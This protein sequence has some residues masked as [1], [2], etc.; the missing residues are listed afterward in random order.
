[1][2]AASSS[3]ATAAASSRPAV[4]IAVAKAA[5]AARDEAYA[6]AEKSR[7]GYVYGDGAE[8]SDSNS[9]SKLDSEAT[10]SEAE[11]APAAA[12]AAAA[13]AASASKKRKK[14]D[15][16]AK[17]GRPPLVLTD[18]QKQ[19]KEAARLE[20]ARLAAAEHRRL[21]P[22]PKGPGSGSKNHTRVGKKY[23]KTTDDENAEIKAKAWERLGRRAWAAGAAE[24]VAPAPPAPVP[25]RCELHEQVFKNISDCADTQIQLLKLIQDHRDSELK[26]IELTERVGL[27]NQYIEN[28][29]QQMGKRLTDLEVIRSIPSSLPMPPPV[30]SVD[31]SSSAVAIGKPPSI[32]PAVAADDDEAV[33]DHELNRFLNLSQ[34]QSR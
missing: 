15:P 29:S 2:A 30:L 23:K 21:H 8:D 1:M 7:M 6:L 18:E 17:R 28:I 9:N 22:R 32:L 31:S 4:L 14:G 12:A 25:V 19:L 10:D 5:K 16:P 13:S 3:A 33:T 34:S 24:A 26:R 20:K 11:S 27:L